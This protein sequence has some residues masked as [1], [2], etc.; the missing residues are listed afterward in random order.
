MGTRER[1]R[2]IGR[3]L[4][5]GRVEGGLPSKI[6]RED[7]YLR[8][9]YVPISNLDF[10]GS[11]KAYILIAPRRQGQR[12][13]RPTSVLIHGPRYSPSYRGKL[14]VKA[15]FQVALQLIVE[16]GLHDCPAEGEE[17]LL[18]R[19]AWSGGGVGGYEGVKLLSP[20]PGTV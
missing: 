15:L 1:E 4:S 20:S 12:E 14:F 5:D 18:T 11:K 8:G 2:D 13:A 3:N 7:N 10:F 6:E 19:R 17:H 9:S 16:P